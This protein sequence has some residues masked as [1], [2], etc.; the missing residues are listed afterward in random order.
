MIASRNRRTKDRIGGR[1][2]PA[3]QL[4]AD[5][6]DLK[7]S[8][9]ENHHLL[10]VNLGDPDR[11]SREHERVAAVDGRLDAETPGLLRLDDADA[12]ESRS[13]RQDL[14]RVLSDENPLSRPTRKLH[15]NLHV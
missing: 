3:N 10:G 13:D 4:G 12:S 1:G 9:H 7:R 2:G 15:T 5:D 6:G 8:I 11:D 14:Q